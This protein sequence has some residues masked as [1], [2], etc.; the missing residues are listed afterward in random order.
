M[1]KFLV[2]VVVAIVLTNKDS[3]DR[4][5]E[6]KERQSHPCSDASQSPELVTCWNTSDFLRHGQSYSAF[7]LASS[8]SSFS[9]HPLTGVFV[10]CLCSC[11]CALIASGD[12][13]AIGFWSLYG[14]EL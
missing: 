6:A 2:G 13:E 1:K 4:L 14:R 10:F 9:H 3:F 7:Q 11:Q 5:S 12:P 8:F